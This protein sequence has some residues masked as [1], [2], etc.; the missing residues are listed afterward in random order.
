[1]PKNKIEALAQFLQKEPSDILGFLFGSRI[2]GDERLISDWDI[3]IYFPPE[4]YLEK[5]TEKESP[6]EH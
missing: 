3:G 5:E 4:E 1:M 2:K 6:E